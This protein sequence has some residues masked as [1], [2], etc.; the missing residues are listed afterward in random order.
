MTEQE[1]IK[2]KLSHMVDGEVI[3]KIIKQALE[4]TAEQLKVKI[5]CQD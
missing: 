3:A 5:S 1:I 4:M 2:A